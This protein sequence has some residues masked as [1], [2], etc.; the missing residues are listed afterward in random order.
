VRGDALITLLGV[1]TAGCIDQLDRCA[2]RAAA[3]GAHLVCPVPGWT[4]RAFDLYV[5]SAWDGATPLPVVLAIH[6]GGGQRDAALR[7]TCPGADRDSPDCLHAVADAMG[8]A[9]VYPDGTS[10]PVFKGTRTWNAGGGAGEFECVSGPACDGDVDDVAYFEDLLAEL[11][12]TVPV[13][14]RRVYATG[15]SNGGAMSHRLACALPD[16]IA[17]IAPVGGGNQWAETGGAC[18]GLVPVLHIHGSEDLCWRY[19]AS[20]EKCGPLP[21]D[22]VHVGI[23]ETMEGWR[24]RNG[25]AADTTEEALP[26]T[27]PADGTTSVRIRWRGCAAATELVRIDGGGHT[28]PDGDPLLSEDIVGRTERDW[29][30]NRLILEFFLAHAKP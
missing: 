19:E 20:A 14:A 7:G 2:G 16:R 29:N 24:V 11:A 1:S 26:D 23:P 30:G 3:P 6:G 13:D 18:P 27:D 8:V 28:W 5:P 15:L 22:G 4:D 12:A 10:T 25:C 17:A 21:N 9:V